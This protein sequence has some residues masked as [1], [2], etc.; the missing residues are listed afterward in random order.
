[1]IQYRCFTV[2]P[3]EHDNKFFT[4]GSYQTHC[5][6]AYIFTFIPVI[7]VDFIIINLAP[8]TTVV[9]RMANKS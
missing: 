4:V 3:F 1:M 6:T 2:Y 5:N 8:L 9:L 7:P